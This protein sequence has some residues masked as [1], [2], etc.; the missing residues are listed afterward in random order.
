MK[1]GHPFAITKDFYRSQLWGNSVQ[2]N[3][4][5]PVPLSPVAVS[6]YNGSLIYQVV[7][8]LDYSNKNPKIISFVRT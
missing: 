5:Q 2:L 6:V 4:S 8:S 3:R 1:L 7:C